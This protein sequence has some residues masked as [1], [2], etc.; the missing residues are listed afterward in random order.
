[1]CPTRQGW[2]ACL[3]S[4]LCY[5]L[6]FMC[7]VLRVVCCV[8]LVCCELHP[9][10]A[11]VLLAAPPP[12][13]IL[14]SRR[15][16]LPFSLDCAV[17]PLAYV[18][19]VPSMCRAFTSSSIAAWAC[20]VL[21]DATLTRACLTCL[22]VCFVLVCAAGWHGA[23]G[24]TQRSSPHDLV[25]PLAVWVWPRRLQ[26]DAAAGESLPP[27]P[28]NPGRSSPMLDVATVLYLWSPCQ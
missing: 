24:A 15:P 1:M 22:S 23:A 28:L 17:L 12:G 21:T 10:V 19:K 2:R 25:R 7:C 13:C 3:P 8:L 4:V 20:L 27:S 11:C 16:L 14:C 6:C 9:L 18:R 5:V 26:H